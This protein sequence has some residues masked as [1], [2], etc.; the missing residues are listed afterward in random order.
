[1]PLLSVIVPVYNEEKT[2]R[3]ILEKI[4]AVPIDKEIIVVDDASTD[5]TQ[6]I[7]HDIL[8][9]RRLNLSKVIHHSH[10][11]G[12]GAAFLT[13]LSEVRGDYI[14]IQDA[15]LE[16]EPQDYLSLIKPLLE[17]RADITLGARFS[18][19]FSGIMI[20]KLGN[21][22]LT[23]FL[24][25]VFGCRLN[26]YA[27]CY[28]MARRDIFLNLNL[29]SKGFEIDVEIICKTL[30]KNL[31]ILEVP[32]SYFPRSYSGGK[33]IRWFDGLRAMAGIVKYRF[34]N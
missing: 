17:N 32:I 23:G 8:K 5:D 34:A 30:K 16:Y 6:A 24:N 20:H 9:N 13:G 1:M 31:R 15:D 18:A 29:A 10:N 28:K 12:K 19:G 22:F 7:L 11:K 2:I 26:D 27:T 25:F 4:T 21:R 3:Q 14:I 33:K